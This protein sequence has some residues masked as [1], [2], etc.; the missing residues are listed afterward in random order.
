[1][2]VIRRNIVHKKNLT[3]SEAIEM[4]MNDNGGF[5]PLKYI[6]ENIEKYRK[7]SGKTPDNTIQE[8]VQR[9]DRF[10]RIALGIYGLTEFLE[11]IEE[12]DLGFFTTKENKIIFKQKQQI[13]STEKIIKQK[14]RIGQSSFRNDLLKSLKKCPITQIDEKRLLIASHIKPWIHS[15]NEERL[16]PNNGFLLSPLYDKLFDKGIGLITFTPDKEILISKKLSIEN[17]AR[18]NVN[19]MDYIAD[20]PIDGREEF[21]EYHKKYIFQG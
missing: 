11:N 6:Y 16:N 1:V 2:I 18:L 19:N 12:Y 7:K 3:Y 15:N 17:R 21:L 14:V 10:T 4:V 8:R 9:D 20:L 5:A 13:E